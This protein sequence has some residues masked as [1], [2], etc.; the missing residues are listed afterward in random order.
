MCGLQLQKVYLAQKYIS[1]FILYTLL[2]KVVLYICGHIIIRQFSVLSYQ[3]REL[4]NTLLALGEQTFFK[5][6]IC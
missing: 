2:Y 3:E 4:E 6:R 1:V 5:T